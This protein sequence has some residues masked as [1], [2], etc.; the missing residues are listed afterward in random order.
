[1]ELYG[2]AEDRIRAAE[3][4]QEDHYLRNAVYF[5]CRGS[6]PSGSSVPGISGLRPDHSGIYPDDFRAGTD[7]RDHR[8]DPGTVCAFSGQRDAGALRL[9]PEQTSERKIIIKQN[10]LYC[11]QFI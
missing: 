6:D 3:P 10:T 1:M 4:L 7:R 2:R 5:L 8:M 11:F 9:L